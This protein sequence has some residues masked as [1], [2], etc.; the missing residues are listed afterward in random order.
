MQ[1]VMGPTAGLL[2]SQCTPLA[3]RKQAAS[4]HFLVDVLRE[5]DVSVLIDVVHVFVGVF[6]F[7]GVMRHV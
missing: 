6:N 7:V 5:E 3:F 1:F 4:R 2:H